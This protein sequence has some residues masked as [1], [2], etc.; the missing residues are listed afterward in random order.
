MS[1]EATLNLAAHFVD[2]RVAEGMG[3]RPAIRTDDRLWSYSEVANLSSAFAS[4]LA[5]ADIR[6]EERVIVA[7]P[8]GAPF[9]GALFGILRRG[10]VVVMVNPELPAE[11]LTYF[12]EYTGAR[13]ALVH[14]AYLPAFEKAD[15]GRLAVPNP[16]RRRRRRV[17]TS[18]CR[19]AVRLPGVSDAS[20]RR[21]DLAVQRRHHRP[22]EGGRATGPI[23][24][25]HD[26]EVRARRAG[27]HR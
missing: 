21:G 15:G 20:R 25:E 10:A 16:F 3:S 14:R 17:S 2:A 22:T 18:S 23:V 7:L 24:C 1:G 4:V 5:G 8:D 11:L 27:P 6:P 9:V 12:F 19:R 26:R 13:A